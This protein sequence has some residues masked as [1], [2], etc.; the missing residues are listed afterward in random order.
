M[1]GKW[2][3]VDL[4]VTPRMSPG[5]SEIRRECSSVKRAF[6]ERALVQAL[7]LVLAS[8]VA[9]SGC[10]PG[11]FTVNGRAVGREKYQA[12]VDRRIAVVRRNNPEELEGSRGGKLVKDTRLE[13]ATEMIR[14]AL[15]EQ[16]AAKLSVGIAPGAVKQRIEG[17]RQ[18]AGAEA[19]SQGLEKQGITEQA[20]ED[21][22]RAEL[23]VD[24]LGQKVCEDVSVTRDE[25]QSYY[26][27]HK[28]LFARSLMVHVA[29]ILLNTRGEAEAVLNELKAGQDFSRLAS[30]ISR[31]GATRSNGGD[32][33]WIEQGSMDPALE[34]AAFALK[35]GETSGVVSASD[36]FHII[37][38]LDR[39]EGSVP[40]FSEVWREAIS[41]LETVRKEE[42]F[43]DWLRTV[44]AN[45]R[46]ETGGV[47]RWEPGLG[48]VVG[49]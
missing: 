10:S 47:G 32:L 13:V 34:S 24:A 46:V 9:A 17:E 11:V 26:L 3:E 48:K 19:F 8:A 20:Y 28:D 5:R 36:G 12:E 33:G 43:S 22:V 18:A 39:R 41:K 23:L 42:K 2:L 44:Y 31:D 49:D 1:A 14:R 15:M 21:T 35:S 7:A 4:D 45:A 38:V 30:S 37:K 29:H 25:A 16:E 40:A 6:A 27:T